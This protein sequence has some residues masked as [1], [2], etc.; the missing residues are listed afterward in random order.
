MLPRR[1][2]ILD[3]SH[4]HIHGIKNTVPDWTLILACASSVVLVG[5]LLV[6]VPKC[7]KGIWLLVSNLGQG[8]VECLF[9][10]VPSTIPSGTLENTWEEQGWECPKMLSPRGWLNKQNQH[11]GKN[12][13]LLYLYLLI[14]LSNM[15]LAPIVYPAPLGGGDR[16]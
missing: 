8:R 1:D 12:D 4:D 10:I 7:L 13:S 9:L 11:K 15:S 2:S 3:L 14:Y 6:S 16:C 5:F